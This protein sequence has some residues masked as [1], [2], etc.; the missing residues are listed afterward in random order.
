MDSELVPSYVDL[1]SL[2]APYPT[3]AFIRVAALLRHNG[4][5][6]GILAAHRPGAIMDK[7]GPRFVGL[8]FVADGILSG[9]P[10]RMPSY[11]VARGAASRHGPKR[12]SDA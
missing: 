6:P 3:I 11:G 5:V 8:L 7:S 12:L 9:S 10:W 1:S 4:P 2:L